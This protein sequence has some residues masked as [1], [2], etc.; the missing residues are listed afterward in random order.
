[1]LRQS[2]KMAQLGTLT[3]GVAHELE[4]PAAAVQRGA[5]NSPTVS[6]TLLAAESALGR[7]AADAGPVGTMQLLRDD[8][9]R[10][11]ATRR[12]WTRLP[13]AIGKRRWRRPGAKRFPGRRI[14][15]DAGGARRTTP[16]ELTG[17]RRAKSICRP[18][19][20]ARDEHLVRNRLAEVA[21]GAGRIAE[22]VKALKGYA[23]LDQAPVQEVD[24][25]EGIDSTLVIL[26]H[27]LKA[28]IRV[29]RQFA[30]DLPR[31]SA[32]GSEL[33][34]V[35]TNI[36]DNAAD[37]L[38]DRVKDGSAEI[39]IRTRREGDFI[40]VDI[41]D[42]GPGIPADIQDRIFEAFFTTKPPGRGRA[43]AS[44]SAT[45]SSCSGT[46]ATCASAPGRARRHSR[47]AADRRRPAAARNRRRCSACRRRTTPS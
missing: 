38:A 30:P 25:H 43:S 18:C 3:A 46:A 32:W 10:A 1:M 23:Y 17:W 28:G 9:K 2:E 34:Q 36:L 13:R 24:V 41:H 42:N 11:P 8:V 31:I 39:T 14:G 45:G 26:R 47:S 22:I 40:A 12:S 44:T 35:W 29:V 6:R 16:N 7:A 33:N 27:K 37:A 21:Q 4:H 20:L 5:V 19:A 15:P